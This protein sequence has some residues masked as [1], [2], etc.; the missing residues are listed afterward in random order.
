MFYQVASDMQEIKSR[1]Q[2][3]IAEGDNEEKH[4]R[5]RQS[6]SGNGSSSHRLTKEDEGKYGKKNTFLFKNFLSW[7][8]KPKR[9]RQ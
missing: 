4:H 7:S 1:V 8:R 5:S 9:E 3:K 2:N 6:H